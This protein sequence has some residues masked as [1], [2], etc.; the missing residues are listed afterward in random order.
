MDADCGCDICTGAALVA[1]LSDDRLLGTSSMDAFCDNA[2]I[3]MFELMVIL[4]PINWRW[5]K[6]YFQMGL[7]RFVRR[8]FD[9]AKG[10]QYSLWRAFRRSLK[11]FSIP[12]QAFFSIKPLT[13]PQTF[14]VYLISEYTDNIV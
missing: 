11:K 4:L 6:E 8:L 1:D 10:M 3:E 9:L 2:K 5:K 12:C 7:P 13:T 14:F